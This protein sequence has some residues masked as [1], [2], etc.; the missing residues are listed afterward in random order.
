MKARIIFLLCLGTWISINC[1]QGQTVLTNNFD[2]S[3]PGFYE[4]VDNDQAVAQQFL[5]TTPFTIS[6]VSLDLE[7]Q[8]GDGEF[9]VEL[10]SSVDNA[11]G[12]EIQVLTDA[13]SSTLTS[14]SPLDI[15]DLDIS[16]PGSSAY[17]IVA[18][19]VTLGEDEETDNSIVWYMTPSTS[20]DGPGY[21]SVKYVD[22]GGGWNTSSDPERLEVIGT[23]VPESSTTGMLLLAAPALLFTWRRWRRV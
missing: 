9:V 15:D 11:P 17:F 21:S 16:L 7:P 19:G 4:D 5:T 8:S 10:W 12:S 14:G 2:Q 22:D 13:D 18:D 20:G 6:E 23:A 1:A 3:N